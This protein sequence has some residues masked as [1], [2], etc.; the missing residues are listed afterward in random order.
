MTNPV[1]ITALVTRTVQG[2]RSA[3]TRLVELYQDMAYGTALSILG[4]TSDAEDAVQDAMIAAYT[5]LARLR[6][7]KTFGSWLRSIVRRTAINVLKTRQRKS[8]A[9]MEAENAV[10]ASG[11]VSSLRFE[12]L[13][14]SSELRDAVGLLPPVQRE[15]VFAYYMNGSTYE[16]TAD[17]LGVPVSTLRARLRRAR[18]KLRNLLD[19]ADDISTPVMKEIAMNRN[20]VS[21]SVETVIARTATVPVEESLVLGDGENVVLFCAM[22]TDVEIC[23][24]A[25][26]EVKVTGTKSSIGEDEETAQKSVEGLGVYLDRTDDYLA[27]GPHEGSAFRFPGFKDDGSVKSA[28]GPLSRTWAG[29]LKD[30]LESV[31]HH[32][33]TFP[34]LVAGTEGTHD[35]IRASLGKSL[36]I[37][38]ARET[39]E[40]ICI[41][42]DQWK[43]EIRR[44][45]T[46]NYWN[47]RIAH[48]ARGK[49]DLVV[50]LPEGATITVFHDIWFHQEIRVR[51]YNGT[52]NMVDCRDVELEDVQGDVR[53]LNCHLTSA[54]K[55]TGKLTHTSYDLGATNW[56]GSR[57]T[58]PDTQST[59]IERVT[60]GLA[61]DLGRAN[62]ELSHVS[63]DV[64]VRNRF[65]TTRFHLQEHVEGSRYHV[66]TDSGAVRIFAGEEALDALSISL[67][68]L[69]GTI[70]C[71]P[72]LGGPQ[73]VAQSTSNR[74]RMS[75]TTVIPPREDPPPDLLAISRDGDILVEKT[76]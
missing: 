14:Q 73:V 68:S 57:G 23:T 8:F 35:I 1:D 45:F 53:L 3:F 74:Q 31:F 41:P 61:V 75:V 22:P 58:R 26:S 69:C 9:S 11:R 66:E 19:G 70:D 18:V 40:D 34:E 71:D 43:G 37:T 16:R 62:L 6:D 29:I 27:E 30:E 48:G 54:R 49:A 24:T 59:S 15:A 13:Q 51:G 67:H 56:N 17:Y 76:R 42:V 20:T 36:R 39:M 63:G 44:G 52:V 21:E 32:S 38:V 28:S 55:I 4:N 7:P 60:G 64:R 65:G 47:D 46:P 2:D 72:L 50:A 5:S 12:K 33:E 10:Y 25:G